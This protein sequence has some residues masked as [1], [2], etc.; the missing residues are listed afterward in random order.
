[1][2]KGIFHGI[3]TTCASPI[4]RR[5]RR[6]LE[7]RKP[8]QLERSKRTQK[9]EDLFIAARSEGTKH[10]LEDVSYKQAR[11]TKGKEG[12]HE[13]SSNK[14]NKKRGEIDVKNAIQ[15]ME[16]LREGGTQHQ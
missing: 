3:N 5:K 9:K 15:E 11:N 12:R 4:D 8:Y 6:S 16:G 14:E 13:S 2:E 7:T 1:V 10:L